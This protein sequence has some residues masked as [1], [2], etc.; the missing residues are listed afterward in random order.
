MD[1]VLVYVCVVVVVIIVVVVVVV[2]VVVNKFIPFKVLLAAHYT[3]IA[4]GK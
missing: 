3:K 4:V 1:V 2:A